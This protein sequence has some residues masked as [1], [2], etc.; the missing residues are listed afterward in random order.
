MNLGTTTAYSFSRLCRG[1]KTL[2]YRTDTV[3]RPNERANSPQ[4]ISV[5]SLD[6]A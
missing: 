2:K 6:A 4:R 1:P 5:A 3:S